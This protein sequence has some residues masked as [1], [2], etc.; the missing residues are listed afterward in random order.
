MRECVTT[1]ARDC[2]K[3]H[4]EIKLSKARKM[5]RNGLRTERIYDL[6]ERNNLTG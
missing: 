1:L 4:T 2:S 3:Q 5:F 6:A